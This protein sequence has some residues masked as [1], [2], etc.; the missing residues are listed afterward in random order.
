MYGV[1]LILVHIG[2]LDKGTLTYS[3]DMSD[4]MGR[5]FLEWPIC[6]PGSSLFLSNSNLNWHAFLP[7]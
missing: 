7:M 5:G 2:W 3:A 1:N 4:K 6:V